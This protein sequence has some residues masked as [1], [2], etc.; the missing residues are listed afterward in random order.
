MFKSRWTFKMVS[1]IFQYNPLVIISWVSI[2]WDNHY[3]FDKCLPKGA[4]SLCHFFKAQFSFFTLD[5]DKHVRGFCIIS[6]WIDYFFFIGRANSDK[7]LKDD[8][9]KCNFEPFVAM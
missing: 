6:H 1:D 4:S 7:C 8:L 3:Y 9:K 2:K 5:N